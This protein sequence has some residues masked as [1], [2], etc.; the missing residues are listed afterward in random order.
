MPELDIDFNLNGVENI[1]GRISPEEFK[2]L[3][4]FENFPIGIYDA[5][6]LHQFIKEIIKKHPGRFMQLDDCDSGTVTLSGIRKDSLSL[7]CVD[8]GGAKYVLA[9]CVN[10]YPGD[11]E[12][13]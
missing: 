13:E 3:D 2:F 12:S 8:V 11:C 6:C 9:P 1:G 5:S 7:L 4:K 10:E